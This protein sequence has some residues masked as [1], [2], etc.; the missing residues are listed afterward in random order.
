MNYELWSEKHNRFISEIRSALNDGN[1]KVVD[2]KLLLLIGLVMKHYFELLEMKTSAANLEVF[3]VASA[4][5]CTPAE[6]NLWWIGGF[7]PS[8]VLQVN[9]LAWRENKK[10]KRRKILN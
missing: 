9:A 6:R 8:Q 5:W 2:D 10:K 7:R 4:V 3:N 1:K